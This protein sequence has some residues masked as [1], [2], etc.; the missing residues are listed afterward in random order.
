MK[1]DQSSPLE[2]IIATEILNGV[3]HGIAILDTDFRIAEMNSF[4]EVLTGFSSS[5]ARG[6]LADFI[7]R[8]NIGN[9]IRQFREV[10]E[11]EECLSLTGD[12]INQQHKK[13]PVHF[14]ISPLRNATGKPLGLLVFLEDMSAL[15]SFDQ[16]RHDFGGAENILGHSPKMQEIF[17]LMP[18]LAHTDASILIT[19]ETG[20]GKDMVAEAIHEESKRSRHPFI[21]INCGALP[22]ALLE[23]ELF[24]HVRGAFTGA[25]KDKPGLFRLAQDGT[26]FLT[27]I[28]DLP[29]PLQVKLLSVL[30][31]KEFFPVGA[32]KKT[33]VNVRII[34]ATHRPLR[35]LVSKG[36][37]R[38]DL[39][40]RL[41][42]LRL[43]LPAL[44]ER[45]G[46]IRLLLDYFLREFN[47][48]LHKKIKGFSKKA[49]DTLTA[50]AYPGNV[51]ELRN[52]VEYS[53][54][55]CQE[56]KVQQKSLPKYLLSPAM[57]QSEFARQ[58]EWPEIAPETTAQ[59]ITEPDQARQGK[60]NIGGWNEIEK[61]MILEA[62]KKAKGNR[63][64]T[65]RNLGW[66]RTTLW[67]K[68]NRYG[69]T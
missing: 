8:S 52:I 35:V 24:G 31:D 43:H 53:V 27:E 49:L 67:R 55:I 6:V 61:E 32:V 57:D 21:K 16:K 11:K 60:E 25:V 4:L 13:I 59:K 58:N 63:S 19:G 65:A 51:R 46:D 64:E 14:T 29:L 17:E 10:L 56:K 26:I 45:E 9:D 33:Q 5:D 36:E 62:M 3:P 37:F 12:I 28:G 40:Y 69:L 1:P 39:F 41:N 48:N 23:S 7:L 34:A 20:T 18:V 38:E 44:R 50:Y 22:E 54:N 2:R 30:D 15:Q 68:M 42:V 47:S 66:G